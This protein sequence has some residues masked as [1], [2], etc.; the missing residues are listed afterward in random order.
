MKREEAQTLKNGAFKRA[1]T[2]LDKCV[3]GA[4]SC[5]ANLEKLRLEFPAA[6]AA[7]YVPLVAVFDETVKA[8][9]G[10]YASLVSND[11][12]ANSPTDEMLVKTRADMEAVTEGAEKSHATF[13]D[14]VMAPGKKLL[15]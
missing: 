15:S 12:Q 7:C 10:K 3:A 8:A 4:S 11:I 9:Q 13:K 1:K 2:M 14:E 5:K 6:L